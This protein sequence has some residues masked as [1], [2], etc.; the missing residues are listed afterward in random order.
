M[1]LMPPGKEIPHMLETRTAPAAPRATPHGSVHATAPLAPATAPDL[2]LR[3]AFL[4]GAKRV[5]EL[6]LLV[7]A[8]NEA[9]T[10]AGTIRSL[11][12]QTFA[13][14]AI[15]VID[16]ASTDDTA[17]IARQLG[18]TVV[19]PA[20]N[21]G[22]KAGAQNYG[23]NFVETPFVMAV[24]ADTTLAPDAIE[25]LAAAFID[26]N[27]AAACGFVVPR[28]V[29]TLWE[30]GRYVE[31]LFAFTF[32]KQVQ[33]FY[34]RPLI[35]SGCFSMYRTAVLRQ[36]GG[37]PQRTLAEDMDLT[38]T[39]HQQGY[40][41]RFIVEAVCYPY[42]PRTY[43]F[44]SKQLRRW[45]HGFVQ[46]VRLHWRGLGAVPYL[47]SA[48]A[49]AFWDAA[50]AST[51]YL[52]ALPVVAML[53]HAPWMLLGY[54]IDAPAI[55]VPVLAGAVKRREVRRAL[56]SFPSFFVLRAVNAAFFIEALWSEVARGRHMDVYEKGH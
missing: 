28:E 15:V 50:I 8:Y 46:N 17:E 19:Q 49:V 18:V 13:P 2:A 12:N 3:G 25:R 26:P 7:P 11:Q 47:R 5:L 36:L 24:D 41:V 38:W 39:L 53:F 1:A 55:L 42:E 48:V 37:W 32:Y 43:F 51:V 10:I 23:L 30:R 14:R 44:M 9:A 45:S 33:D 27:T 34:R 22:S 31:Y 29:H 52:L 4:H 56:A 20:V 54:V 6:T 16:D 21:T 35:S 40:G